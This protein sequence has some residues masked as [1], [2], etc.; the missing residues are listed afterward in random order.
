MPSKLPSTRRFALPWLFLVACAVTAGCAHQPEGPPPPPPTV[1]VSYP[2]RREVTNSEEYTGRSAAVESVQVMAEVTGYLDKINFQDGAEVK[3]DEVL[4]K[5]DPRTYQAALNQAQANLRQAQV[6]R[7]SLADTL[8]RDRASPAATPEATLIQDQDNLAEADAAVVAATAAR[9]AAQLNVNFTDVK[10]PI[11]GQIGRTLLTVGNLVIANQTVLS[12]V[13]SL[14]PMYAYFDVDEPTVEHI[15]Q[16]I[17]EGKLPA[18]REQGKK[19][20]VYLGLGSEQGYPHEGYVDFINN[21]VNPSTATLQLRGVFANPKPTVGPRLLSPGQF[22]RIRLP[23]GSPYPALLVVGAAIGTDQNLKYVY[24]LNDKNEVERRD[25]TL[26]T[27]QDGLTVV[28]KG[29]NAGDRV[30]VNGLQHV[31][32][33]MTVKANLV[34]M[35]E[36][37]AEGETGQ[38]PA[39]A[40]NPPTGP[41]AKK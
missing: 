20:P 2:I 27:Q 32:P 1:T 22:V 9:D 40:S 30:V 18:A 5:I 23:I 11:S 34:K 12:T 29:L 13:V 28:A 10:S 3:Q 16:L 26:G 24:V 31:R 37:A 8:A 36:P 15:R 39:G 35:P 14:D 4:Y 41:Q 19:I 21:Q 25:V 17:R 38:A 6:H 33:G 7:Q